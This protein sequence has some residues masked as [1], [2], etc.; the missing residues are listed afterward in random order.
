M[1]TNEQE[2]HDRA[3]TSLHIEHTVN[4]LEAWLE[5]FSAFADVRA[6]RGVT[7]VEVRNGADDP[8]FV[9]IDLDFAT[10]YQA[11]SFLEFLE[12][13][14]WPTAPHFSG[15]PT[16]RLLERVTASARGGQRES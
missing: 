11:R 7:A 8:N 3:M 2:P 1:G 13:Q 9:A 10:L 5:T 14:I 16:T 12:S 4:G 15:T 6:D